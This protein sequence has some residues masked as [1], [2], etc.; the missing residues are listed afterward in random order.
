MSEVPLVGLSYPLPDV[1]RGIRLRSGPS[2][3]GVCPPYPPWPLIMLIAP[4]S[5][6][7]VECVRFRVCNTIK[8]KVSSFGGGSVRFRV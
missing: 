7:G 5:S 2:R 6:Y 1:Q 8:V 3:T 4:R